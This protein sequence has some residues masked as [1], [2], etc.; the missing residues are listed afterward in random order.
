MTTLRI[1]SLNLGWQLSAEHKRMQRRVLLDTDSDLVVLQEARRLDLVPELL[2]GFSWCEHSLSPSTHPAV[3]GIAILG[4]NGVERLDRH[5]LARSAFENEEVY[6]ELA[7]WFRERHLGLDLRL[8]G[9]AALRVLGAHATPGSSEGPGTPTGRLGVG[10]RK[11]WF[12]TRVA[13]WIADWT[14]PYVLALDAN[15]PRRETLDPAATEFHIPFSLD[16]TGQRGEDVLLG[17]PP[18]RPHRARDPW[19]AWLDSAPGRSLRDGIPAEGPLAQSHHTGG[20]WYRYDHLWATPELVPE[21]M[22]YRHDEAVSD[23]ARIEARLALGPS[24]AFSATDR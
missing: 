20:R 15:T 12:H 19:R 9:G 7:R 8:P 17:E 22:A 13:R 2:E 3:L 11:A 23:H 18:L 6:P 16:G 4:R 10:P 14:G 24:P 5:Q 1:V 21:A